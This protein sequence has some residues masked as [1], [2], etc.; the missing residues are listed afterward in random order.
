MEDRGI[1]TLKDIKTEIIETDL[2]IIGGGNAG[3]FA[4]Y[5]AKT[6]NPALKVTIMEK[7]QISRS[8]ATAAGMDAIN[9]YI[10]E[11]RGETPESLVR[12]GRAQL[13]GGPI[14]EDLVLSNA[15]LL[16]ES[17]EM[18]EEWGLPM[19]RDEE[20]YYKLRGRWDI[21]IQG[22][23]LKP[24]MAEKAMEAGAQVY[25]RVAA[26]NLIMAG[27]RCAGAYGLG[28]RDG[29]LY[30]FLAK[31]TIV[32]TGG[33]CGIY[34]S[35]V[36]DYTGSH[37]QTWM[38]PF[39]VGTGY[40][41]GIRAGG[42]MTSLEQR[43]VAIRTKDFCG[44][45]DTL[46]VGYGCLMINGKGEKIMEERYAHLGGEKAPRFLRLNAPMTEWLEGRAPTY[47]DTRRLTQEE[48]KDLREDLLNE[49]PSFVL[50]LA[51]KGIDITKE[52]VEIFG[53][54]PYIVGGHTGSGYWVGL[55]RMTTITG[56]FAAGET[57]GGSPNKFV[58][59]CATEGRLAA[60]SALDYLSGLSLPEFPALQVEEERERVFAPLLR[61]AD[62]D[63]ITA[64]EMEEKLQRLMDEYAGGVSQ[65]YRM[66]EERLK[67]ALQQ[68]KLLQDQTRHLCAADLH[69]LMNIHEVIDRLSV[70]EA[71]LHHLLF[72]KETRW[73][74]WQTRMDYPEVDPA[75]DCFVESRRDP[76]TGEVKVSTRPY[77]QLVPGDR[78]KA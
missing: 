67:Y 41:V 37:H 5:E 58:G 9:T 39:N 24:I 19:V 16:N 73:E 14:R 26:T 38:C 22:E 43:W 66:N 76:A 53:S 27:D 12:W 42:E 70:A 3:C 77:E 8:G 36:T 54:D 15:E 7:A 46:A 64:V 63:G 75:L 65:F 2:L 40:A 61:G 21:S 10:R 71:L 28:V 6:Q 44:P 57:A 68:V 35:P 23:Q 33:A 18:L 17:V 25:N 52:P 11:D 78:T 69:D 4:A 60:R 13:G 56:L 20:G 29:K 31:A 49:R 55:D 59:G 34:R 74:G 32:A 62:F 45:V 50:F 30:V 47:V 1:K 72:R 51:S 48:S